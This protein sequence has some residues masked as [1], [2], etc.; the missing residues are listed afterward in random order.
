[1]KTVPLEYLASL[2]SARSFHALSD[3][4]MRRNA[5]IAHFSPDFIGT[6][7]LHNRPVYVNPAGLRLVELPLDIDVT[8]IDVTRHHPAWVIR[9]MMEVSFPAARDHGIWIGES[10][11]LN[12]GGEEIPVS[13]AIFPHVGVHGKIEYFTFVM[14]DIRALKQAEKA[15]QDSI[16]TI[17][18]LFESAGALM[19]VIELL[20]DGDVHHITD[21]PKTASFFAGCEIDKTRPITCRCL[22]VSE[23]IIKQWREAC[24]ESLQTGLPVHFYFSHEYPVGRRHLS[25]TIRH[26]ESASSDKARFAYVAEDVTDRRKAEI[27]RNKFFGLSLDLFSILSMDGTIVD[28]NAGWTEA[29][30]L[31]ASQLLKQNVMGFVHSEDLQRAISELASNVEGKPSGNF[32]VRMMHADGSTRWVQW[33]SHPSPEEG[34]IYAAG[35]DV[36]SELEAIRMSAEADKLS[37]IGLLAAGVAHEFKNYLGGILGNATFALD[38]MTDSSSNETVKDSLQ[39]IVEASTRANAVAMSLLSYSR[40]STSDFSSEDMVSLLHK[41]LELMKKELS[42][43]AISVTTH[44]DIIPRVWMIPGR[45]QQVLLNLLFNARHAIKENGSITITLHA[46]ADTVFI[47]VRDTGSGILPENLS[48]IFDPFFSTKGVWG[49]DEFAGTGMGLSISRNIAHEHG[50]D[51]TVSSKVGEGATFTLRLPIDNPHAK[52]ST[53]VDSGESNRETILF[54]AG[55]D[56]IAE[57]LRDAQSMGLS[58]T[59]CDSASDLSSKL[60]GSPR[61]CI[62]DATFPAKVELMNAMDLLARAGVPRALIN[63][64]SIGREI[65]VSGIPSSLSFKEAPTLHTIL[66]Q[67]TC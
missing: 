2:P 10:A 56:C 47:D 60:N 63:C 24:L 38:E 25:T 29:L 26:I 44:Y 42:S 23:S 16:A 7:D 15:L 6:M 67:V 8:T 28:V 39:Q 27:E 45:I 54:S 9:Q 14:R 18:G 50:G 22:G 48:R 11:L 5:Q 36:T 35:R 43:S 59:V 65:A 37:A 32:L 21:N 3:E 4:E 62:V 46:T 20:D 12:T 51:L 19:G 66:N 30:G 53:V 49:K 40:S 17:R 31:P 34:L 61:L 57:Y 64:A 52:A 13:Q 58:L 55:K 1:M 33:R 41:T